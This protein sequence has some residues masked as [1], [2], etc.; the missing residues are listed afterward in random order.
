VFGA[1]FLFAP[2]AARASMAS[3]VP[4]CTP[5]DVRVAIVG[6]DHGAGTV[7]THIAMR[8]ISSHTC[9]L[10][11]FPDLGLTRSNGANV[12]DAK[13]KVTHFGPAANVAL[14]PYANRQFD[15]VWSDVS[16][17]RNPCRPVVVAYVSFWNQ[18]PMYVPVNADACR[19]I[20]EW[21]M[22]LH[23]LPM[24]RPAGPSASKA[25]YDWV[26]QNG[27][28]VY[29]S[30]YLVGARPPF[31]APVHA[32]SL[33]LPVAWAADLEPEEQAAIFDPSSNVLGI[34]TS[35]PRGDVVSTLCANEPTIPYDI[36]YYPLARIATK[37]G[38][39]LGMT[40][41][42]V[43]AIDGPAR[44]LHGQLPHGYTVIG[45]AWP[46][47]TLVYLFLHSRVM[48]MLSHVHAGPG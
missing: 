7:H 28:C 36:G 4:H 11:A 35:Y 23:V 8:N 22:S 30:V 19:T 5:A 14:A 20:Q 29:L 37:R 16:V 13:V 1:L 12:G 25:W 31:H 21:S 27:K 40:L 47:H 33:T 34:I 24:G 45:Y 3:N 44:V 39:R 6:E 15:I 41:A 26:G 43:T 2:D 17:G 10:P 38:I 18:T 42:Q 46:N 48:G 32:D 9:A